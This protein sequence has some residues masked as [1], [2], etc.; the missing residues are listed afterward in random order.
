MMQR[1]VVEK[2][3]TFVIMTTPDYYPMSGETEFSFLFQ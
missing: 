1:S 3:A 2:T